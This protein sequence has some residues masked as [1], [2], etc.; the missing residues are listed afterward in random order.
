MIK[1]IYSVVVAVCM[2]VVHINFVVVESCTDV[3][4]VDP[5]RNRCMEKGLTKGCVMCTVGIIIHY[6]EYHYI[7]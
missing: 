6:Y 3:A 4:K 2:H 5:L 7:C 1:K